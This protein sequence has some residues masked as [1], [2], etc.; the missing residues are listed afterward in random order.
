VVGARR[1]RRVLARGLAALIR[2]LARN[3]VGA[4][5]G[6]LRGE[7]ALGAPGAL[8]ALGRRAGEVL[9]GVA[10]VEAAGLPREELIFARGA[11]LARRLRGLVLVL[12]DLAADAR[13]LGEVRRLICAGGACVGGALVV[14]VLKAVVV[15]SG[16]LGAANSTDGKIKSSSSASKSLFSRSVP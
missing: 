7:L 6:A 16:T 11:G 5:T 8:L 10:R 3:A 9:A 4:N 2:V 12:T 15:P 14:R 13:L 1:A